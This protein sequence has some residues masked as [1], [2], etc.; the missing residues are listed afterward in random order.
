LPTQR[1]I[2]AGVARAIKKHGV[3]NVQGEMGVG[4]SSVGSAVM[5]LLNA[6][7]A[8]VVCPPHLVPKWIREI[9]ET[10]PGARAMELKRIGR[11][12]DDPGDVNDVSAGS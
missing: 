3:G 5:E 11:N 1:H 6:Y 12:A 10:I 9:E 7:P 8:I 4:K 2:A